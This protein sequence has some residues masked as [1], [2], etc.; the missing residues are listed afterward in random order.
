MPLYNQTGEPM[1]KLQLTAQDII[2][3]N[4]L[5]GYVYPRDEE[6]IFH[7]SPEDFRVWLYELNPREALLL[8]STTG[9]NLRI[10]A[11]LKTK[12]L[13]R[14]TDFIWRLCH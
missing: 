4:R 12:R 11:Q 6:I 5:R 7:L 14:F 3:L 13:S 1:P 10:R 9:I 8:N 2:R